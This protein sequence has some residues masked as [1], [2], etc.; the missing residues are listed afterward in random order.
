MKI[1]SR[2]IFTGVVGESYVCTIIDV[3]KY[4]CYAR[5][6]SDSLDFSIWVDMDNLSLITESKV[7]DV[8]I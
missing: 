3:D 5:I 7:T 8:L 4:G 1:G 6:N 2:A